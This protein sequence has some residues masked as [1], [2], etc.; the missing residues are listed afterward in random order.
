MNFH[1]S[2]AF[3]STWLLMAA[4]TVGCAAP[5]AAGSPLPVSKVGNIIIYQDEMFYSAFLRSCAVRG[6]FVVA[7]NAPER[8][9]L[10]E[11]CAPV[12][13]VIWCWCSRRTV[14]RRG[15]RSGLIYANRSAA[16]R[17]RYVVQLRDGTCVHQLR[18]GSATGRWKN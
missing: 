12:R 13:T 6:N 17:T 9:S 14:E 11:P 18:L 5:S 1:C 7:F 8:R 16:R 4:N 3:L 15:I 2:R 10:G